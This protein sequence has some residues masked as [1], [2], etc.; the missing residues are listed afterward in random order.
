MTKKKLKS[1]INQSIAYR[2]D[3]EKKQKAFQDFHNVLCDWS[4]M[5]V[6]EIDTCWSYLEWIRM[7]DEW[8]Y[9]I[10]DWYLL[11]SWYWYTKNRQPR[12]I[13]GKKYPAK[14]VNDLVVLYFA[15]KDG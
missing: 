2:N 10:L 15:M 4:I 6:I 5:S 8:L 12:T 14:T 7:F 1:I 11:D 3:D 13:K 9:D